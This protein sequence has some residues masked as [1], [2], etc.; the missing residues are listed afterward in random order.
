[1]K[2]NMLFT[3]AVTSLVACMLS[4]GAFGQEPPAPT[5]P[6]TLAIPLR[7]T[8]PE[9]AYQDS[10]AGTTL[11]MWSGTITSPLDNKPY[12]YTLLGRKYGTPGPNVEGNTP[13]PTYVIPVRIDLLDV[14][15]K[16]VYS[17]DPSQP[18][19]ACTGSA[20]SPVDLV[21]NSPLFNDLQFKWGGTNLGTTQYIDAQLRG[22]FWQLVQANPFPWHNKFQYNL[23]ELQPVPVPSTKW[24]WNGKKDCSKY[25]TVN[26]DWFDNYVQQTVIPNAKITTNQL[27]LILTYNV[28]QG[29]AYGYHSGYSMNGNPV[30]IYGVSIF[31]SSTN[32]PSAPDIDV[33]AHELGEVMN[34]PL[35][36]NANGNGTPAW[37]HI[38][39]QPYC[40][41]NF[42]VGDPLTPVQ[43]PV[44]N[45][46]GFNYHPQELAFFAWFYRS[47]NWGVNGWYS[48]N[49]SLV[50]DNQLCSKL[51]AVITSPSSGPVKKLF[52]LYLV[53]FPPNTVVKLTFGGQMLG[54]LTTNGAGYVSGM[55]NVP[56]PSPTG[57]QKILATWNAGQ[58]Y[59]WFIV[60]Q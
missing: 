27:A 20:S 29:G 13:I 44:I 11:P 42:E 41:T 28:L 6:Q 17:F 14:D 4:V 16:V 21:K 39:Q 9:Q 1:M 23:S 26:F 8:T 25:A 47:A 60:T 46:N 45:L 37:G 2:R 51:P 22:E 49:G 24:N 12:N 32:Y 57:A 56:D 58:A 19:M 30:Q 15:D 7:G 55:F 59:S 52:A 40:Q 10:L 54:T 5:F 33:L 34:N 53:G 43:M 31:N 18:D 38:G 35:V 50:L 48:T 36:S 3:L